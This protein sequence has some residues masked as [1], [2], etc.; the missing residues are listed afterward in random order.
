MAR[1]G[2]FAALVGLAV[3]AACAHLDYPADW[4][5]VQAM[6]AG[7]PDLTGT[8]SNGGSRRAAR[9]VGQTPTVIDFQL[10]YLFAPGAP[11]GATH[12]TLLGPRDGQLKVTVW[13]GSQAMDVHVLTL[14]RDFQCEAGAVAIE[15]GDSAGALSPAG[16]VV[17]AA[18]HEI[19]YL[20]KAQDGAL[21]A[22]TQST[23]LK[24][25]FFVPHFPV[26]L[27]TWDRFAA[28]DASKP[29]ADR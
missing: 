15:R 24:G 29:D 27:K 10:V 13:Q 28:Y 16:T 1:I 8:Y 11:P 12:L 19:D 2:R 9:L 4:V 14:D 7:C 21:I 23:G 5:P 22:R 6:P 17:A 3:L 26:P 20:M 18:G 25:W